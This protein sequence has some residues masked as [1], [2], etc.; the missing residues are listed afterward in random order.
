MADVKIGEIYEARVG[1]RLA[2]VKVLEFRAGYDP[3]SGQPKTTI[4]AR[5]L[6][7]GRILHLR[8][9]RRLRR[10]WPRKGKGG[11]HDNR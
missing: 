1:H 2:P 11:D 8:S 9:A 5:N 7:T 6:A 10:K 3:W 4:V